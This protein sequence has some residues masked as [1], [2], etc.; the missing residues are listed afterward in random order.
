MAANQSAP[1]RLNQPSQRLLMLALMALAVLIVLNQANPLTTRLGRDSG[2]YAYVAS[3]LV[4]GH[5]P[6]LSAWEHK[7]PGIFFIDALGLTLAGG[8]RWGIWSVE[9]VFLLAAAVAGFRAL[10]QHFGAGPALGASLIW[11]AGLSLVL[12]GGNF[13][14]EFSLP[15][16]FV[17]LLLFGMTLRRPSSLWLYAALGLATGCT[18]MLR[19]NNAG[20]QVAIV[21]TEA[22]LLVLRQRTWRESLN[23]WL[24]LGAGFVLPLAAAAAYFLRRDAFQA[25]I[26]AAFLFN[27]SY[28]GSVDPLGAF[29]SGIKHLGFAAG[30]ALAG[31]L[32]AFGDLRLQ[33]R[34]RP[35]DPILLWLGLDFILEVVL[36][37][38]SGRN[39]PHYF[40][41]WLPWMAYA[42]ALLI[43]RVAVSF[44]RWFKR[45]AVPALLGTIVVLVLA[46][47]DTLGAYTSAF[48]RVA[49]SKAE[50]QR[51]EL[52]PRYV[53]EH[54]QPG[55]TVYM[56]GGE[57]GVNFLARRDAPTAH[58]SYAQLGPSPLTER[59]SAEFYADIVAH[60]PAL[61]LDQA[62]EELP[63]LT[64]TKPEEWLASRNL[65]VTPYMQEL[66][67]FVHANYVYRTTMA[68]VPVYQLGQ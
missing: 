18:F 62:G 67:D 61:I 63:P 28:G 13:T 50:V 10:E 15:F 52:L 36:S 32:V 25:F 16:S 44:D 39:Y 7:P 53:N 57:A 20:V 31:M 54:T 3:H 27:A 58:F 66:F 38:L 49:A 56:W 12:E 26:E 68:G 35:V 11:L 33:F 24:A 23:G 48:S 5:T 37:G 42:C 22:V 19:P 46:S 34:N 14:E 2:M 60:P 8:T 30:M 9:L 51:Q 47:L 4:R 29:V 43:S 45:F 21:L 65:Y 1:T 17:S 40:I 64:T 6:Y 59:L 41:S 55:D